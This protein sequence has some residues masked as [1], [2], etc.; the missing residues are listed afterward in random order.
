MLP[1]HGSIFQQLPHRRRACLSLPY[2][3]TQSHSCQR[4]SK[5]ENTWVVKNHLQIS[6]SFKPPNNTITHGTNKD[7]PQ[8]PHAPEIWSKNAKM[9]PPLPEC[10]SALPGSVGDGSG[11][12]MRLIST[13]PTPRESNGTPWGVSRHWGHTKCQNTW[14]V[15]DHPRV[16]CPLRPPSPSA[17]PGTNKGDPKPPHAPE[18]GRKKAKMLPVSP[19]CASVL[20]GNVS[21]DRAQ[22]CAQFRRCP[23]PGS[24]MGLPGKFQGRR[25]GG[26]GRYTGSARSKRAHSVGGLFYM[27]CSTIIY[28]IYF[29]AYKYIREACR[30]SDAMKQECETTK[31]KNKHQVTMTKGDRSAGGQ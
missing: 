7:D 25:M 15:F 12:I 18:V 16:S 26:N 1:G 27:Y 29:T 11:A 19:K 20:P 6:C 23:P 13:A 17:G 21:D 14:V 10:A 31:I 22:L 2:T 24:P 4:H 3:A 5:Y 8:G 9:P 28:I 30:I